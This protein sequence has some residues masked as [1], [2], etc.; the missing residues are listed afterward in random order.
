MLEPILAWCLT[1]ERKNVIH[2]RS[3]SMVFG[4]ALENEDC[5]RDFIMENP[6]IYTSPPRASGT[7]FCSKRRLAMGE[8]R[9]GGGA[10]KPGILRL[11]ISEPQHRQVGY[12]AVPR[13]LGVV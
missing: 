11:C 9:V 12:C 2:G 5:N 6:I 8:F 10:L 7:R 4:R 3:T 1:K 13:S